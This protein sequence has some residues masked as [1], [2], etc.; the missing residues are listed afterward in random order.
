M[1]RGA[2]WA[3]DHGVAKKS[4][5]TERLTHT[6]THTHIFPLASLSLPCPDTH[7]PYSASPFLFLLPHFLTQMVEAPPDFSSAQEARWIGGC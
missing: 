5:M 1:D 4:D 7:L 3:T 6:H 2:W